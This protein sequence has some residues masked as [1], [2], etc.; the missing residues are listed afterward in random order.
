MGWPKEVGRAGNKV[1]QILD[2]A[3]HGLPHRKPYAPDING[4]TKSVKT[5]H[6]SFCHDT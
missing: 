3:G 4:V 2:F 1:G 5:S 6:Y